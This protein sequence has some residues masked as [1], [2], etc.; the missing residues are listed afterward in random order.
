MRDAA[1]FVKRLPAGADALARQRFAREVRLTAAVQHAGLPRVLAAAPYRLV[2]ERLEPLSPAPGPLPEAAARSLLRALAAPLAALHARG[3]VH[4]DI[5][6][7]HVLRRG[8]QPVLIDLGVA[9]LVGEDPLEGAECV[10]SPAWMAPE[11]L[12]A[13]P[14][15]PSADIWALGAT[16]AALS[17]GRPLWSGSAAEVLA[18]R[19]SGFAAESVPCWL[20][21]LLSPAPWQR[22]TARSLC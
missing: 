15:H 17:L 13:T 16:V 22:P 8:Q 14:P 19:R 7:A 11:Q 3:I 6:P 2:L 10:G 18:A 20:A 5:K 9:G 12:F 1:P 21:P 4:R